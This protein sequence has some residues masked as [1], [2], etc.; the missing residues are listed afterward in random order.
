MAGPDAGV[1]RV[2]PGSPPA[3]PGASPAERLTPR[4]RFHNTTPAEV[5]Q[6]I[7]GRT[8]GRPGPFVGQGEFGCGGLRR[9]P[10]IRFRPASEVLRWATIR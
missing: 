9:K 1:R 5:Q 10:T 2:F 6:E 8:A 4:R 7:L 3:V